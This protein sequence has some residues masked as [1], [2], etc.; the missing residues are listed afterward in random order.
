MLFL[1]PATYCSVA[2]YSDSGLVLH[3]VKNLIDDLA[4]VAR[5]D[6]VWLDQAAGATVEG[7]RGAS[8]FPGIG[9]RKENNERIAC[10]STRSSVN[11]PGICGSDVTITPTPLKRGGS[12]RT[13][14]AIK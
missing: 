6:S 9:A 11:S 7:G 5:L 13:Y 2:L 10:K 14:I 4:D 3:L 1:R 8:S 12:R